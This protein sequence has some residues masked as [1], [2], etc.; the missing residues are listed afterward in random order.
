M[1]VNESYELINDDLK[2]IF[3]SFIVDKNKNNN[4]YLDLLNLPKE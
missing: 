1:G 2:N 3:S 4:D